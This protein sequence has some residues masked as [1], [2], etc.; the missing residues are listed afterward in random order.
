[1][2]VEESQCTCW[3][4]WL[5]MQICTSMFLMKTMISDLLHG[6]K[7]QSTRQHV[8]AASWLNRRCPA[9][10]DRSHCSH[11]AYWHDVQAQPLADHSMQSKH[12]ASSH[13]QLWSSETHILEGQH[14]DSSQG[15]ALRSQNNPFVMD[16][17]TFIEA[18][19]D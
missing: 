18:F 8:K 14:A 16:H 13:T 3:S 9:A 19:E 6:L 7:A 11:C 17:P 1:M 5:Q 12:H 10:L 4:Q 2:A 15:P